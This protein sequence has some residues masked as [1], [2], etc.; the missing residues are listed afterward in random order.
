MFG[1]SMRLGSVFGIEIRVDSSWVV[2][3]L[4]F[5]YSFYSFYASQFPGITGGTALVLGAA[6][7][8]LFFASV[9]LHELAHSVMAR[10]LGIPVSGIT[11]F[12]FGGVTQTKLEAEE[13][14]DEFAIAI[15]GPLTSLAIAGLF[16]LVV[17]GGAGILPTPVRGGLGYLGWLN[18][19][20]GIFNMVPGFPLDGGRVL[21]SL[22]WKAT[23]SL[24]RATRVAGSSGQVVG[25]I[26][27]G[28]GVLQTFRGNLGGLW[29]AAIGWFLFQAA[30][31]ASQEVVIRSLLRNV[32]ADDLMTPNPVTVPSSIS[33]AAAVD[34]FFLRYDHS[35]FP[36]MDDDQ[37]TGLITLRS[38]RQI[39][40]DQWERRQV[41]S[42]MTPLAETCTVPPHLA[43]D[44]VMEKLRDDQTERVLVV[45]EGLVVG[46][47]TPRDV[48]RWLR[49]SE[50][51]GLARSQAG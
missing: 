18:L 19:L 20:L 23:G 22:V 3:A 21:R 14:G 7:A 15:V 34:D 24:S 51:L 28:I 30:T 5:A 46:I 33:I 50:E 25:A 39:E 16:W 9:L 36:V 44:K 17:N 27:I 26:M 42:A 35:A 11:L 4:L 1:Q 45:S 8:V 48:A 13:P 12:L 41:W 29:T 37:T 47:I 32:A 40:R 49:R 38:V 31:G 2:I 6:T 10:R 43:M